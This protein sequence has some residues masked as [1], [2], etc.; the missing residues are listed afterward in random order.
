MGSDRV[1]DPRPD[2]LTDESSGALSRLLAVDPERADRLRHVRRLPA[3]EGRTAPWPDWAAPELVRSL[4]ARGVHQPWEHQVLAAEHAHAGRHVVLATGTASGKS[5]AFQLPALT[6]VLGSRRGRRRGATVLYLS[7]TKALAQ[8][9]LAGLGRLGVP[10]LAA[11]TVDGDSSPEQRQWAQEHAEYVLTNPDLLHHGLLP[12]HQR[13]AGFLSRLSYVVVDECHHY[14]GVFGAHVAAVLRRLRRVCTAYGASPT[15]VLASATVRDPAASALAL[16]GLEC[17][18]VQEDTA[19]RGPVTLALW[20]PPLLDGGGEQDARTRRSA[21]AECADLMADLVAHDV[22]T[23]TFVRSRH[24]AETVALQASQRLRPVA[25]ALAGRVA[26]YRGGY[27]PEER[28]RLEADLRSGELVGVAATNAL[29]LGVDI[30]GLDAVL[31]AGYPGSRASFWQQ[32]GRAGRDRGPALAVLVGRDDPL[33][34]YLVDHPDVLLGAPLEPTALDPT[35]PHVVGP[36]LCAAAAEVPL[37]DDD[38]GLFGDRALEGAIA[39]AAAGLLRQ[40]GARWFWTGAGRPSDLA[41]LRSSG[42][43]PVALVETGSGRVVGTVDVASAPALVHQGAV[44]LVQGETWLVDRLDLDEGVAELHREDPGFTTTARSVTELEVR[45]ETAERTWGDSRVVRGEV[46]VTRQ[47]V[48]FLR[49]AADTGVVLG[50]ELLDLPA[51][52]LPTV[53]VWWT[54]PETRW[55]AAGLTRTTVAGGVHA[56][57]HAAVGLLPLV[58]GCD[59]SDLGGLS[60]VVHPDTG[61][62][63]VFAHDAHPGGAGFAD[64]G[65]ARARAWLSATHDA[66]ASCDC[67]DGCPSC[68]QSPRCGSGNDPLDKAAALVLLDLLLAEADEDEPSHPAGS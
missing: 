8:D 31:I 46:E 49:R 22:H 30:S 16:T 32:V 21:T 66:V 19:P 34:T 50:E 39:L 59:R 65:F 11:C 63:T 53:A 45:H 6:A 43:A 17:V 44:H 15:F 1:G 38:L 52:C 57:E 55:A 20:E 25:P 40:R 42:G 62:L 41:D 51:R 54:V 61:E 64:Q 35:N 47:V 58:A 33:D 28:R 5:L 13:W 67:T 7:P 10:G 4:Q 56:L 3:R 29:E 27:V 24:A 23:L 37:T 68:V 2:P 18:P 26:A 36:H 14:R 9:Q 48:S 60:A 12:G